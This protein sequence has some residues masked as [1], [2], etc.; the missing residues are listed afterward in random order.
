MKV[1]ILTLGCKVNQFESQAMFRLLSQNGYTVVGEDEKADIAILNSCA[2]TKVSEQKAVK[3]LHRLRRE[4]PF[5][6]IVLTGCM[7]QTMADTDPRLSDVDIV[8]GNK[9]RSDIITV[10]KDYFQERQ[11]L[12]HIEPYAK[13]DDYEPLVVDDFLNRTRAFLKIEDGCNRFCSYC[14]IPYAR[15][16]VRSCSLEYIQQEITALANIGNREVVLIGINL[17]S[18]GNDNGLTCADAVA[19][20]CDTADIRIRLGSLEPESMDL[21]T[22]RRFAQY[23]NFCPQFHLALQ[24]GCD[25]TLRRMNRH[26]TTAEYAAIVH[27]IRTVFENPSLTTDVMVGF[28]GETEDEFAQSLAF[29]ESIG[30]AKVHIFP[31]SRRPGTVADKAPHQ[32]SPD[33]KKERAA[34]MAQATRQSTKNFLLSQLGRVES[35]LI[36]TRSKDGYYEGYTMNY[37]P[38]HVQATPDHINQIV[39]VQLTSIDP[40]GTYL[41]GAAGDPAAECLRCQLR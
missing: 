31:Y 21:A 19:A 26:Y 10:L 14:I 3:L 34:R 24:S 30:Y 28:P 7:A 13:Q 36:E 27:N 35:V 2:V 11:R 6:V 37:T 9:H 33:V 4:N 20:A 39:P 17:S 32:L 1:K 40:T 8:V 23:K 29:V 18:F 16:R 22:L 15:G 12:I 41:L 5:S 38:V 25:A